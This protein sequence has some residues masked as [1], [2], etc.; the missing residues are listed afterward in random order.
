LKQSDTTG[1]GDNSTATLVDLTDNAVGSQGDSSS[2]CHS[3]QLCD[4]DVDIGAAANV[5]TS[6]DRCSQGLVPDTIRPPSVLGQLGLLHSE[7]VDEKI[8]RTVDSIQAEL[9]LRKSSSRVSLKRSRDDDLNGDINDISA[10]I[11]NLLN[12]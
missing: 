9:E 8:G 3:Y 4:A 11:V 1:S 2:D 6:Q 7:L 5:G 10:K 12:L